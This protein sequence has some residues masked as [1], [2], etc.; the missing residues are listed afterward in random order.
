MHRFNFAVTL[1]ATFAVA[2]AASQSHAQTY[3][4]HNFA[5]PSGNTGVT[6]AGISGNQVVG[7][8]T[9]A[10]SPQAQG[11]L[12][13]GSAYTTINDPL[14]HAGTYSSGVSGNYVA[15][16]FYEFG[17]SGGG[18][19]YNI[20]TTNFTTISPAG[21]LQEQGI[22]ANGISGNLVVGD[23]RTEI[24]GAIVAHGFTYDIATASYATLNDPLAPTM[25]GGGTIAA[26]IDGN[27]IVGSYVDSSGNH[28]GMIYNIAAESFTTLD[29]PS[30]FSF[31]EL[32][33]ISGNLIAG[34]Y[35]VSP[36]VI[37]S[38]LYNTSTGVFT[39][40]ADPLGVNGTSVLGIS[41]ST[42]VGSYEDSSS[43]SHAFFALTPEPSSVVL[44]GLGALGFGLAALRRRMRN[45]VC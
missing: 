15:G 5:G 35:D 22:H 16:S 9:S 19:V 34:I 42:L 29:Y 44:L 6:A 7:S 3:H 11:F 4:F 39:T 23:Y 8:F 2:P 21:A 12:Y 32:T 31:T 37:E 18:F 40:V 24:S 1:L 17:N 43:V 25:P 33:A 14:A 10:S 45:N 36:S 38:F 28:E 30:A 26:G 13:D 27:T 41:G 20:A